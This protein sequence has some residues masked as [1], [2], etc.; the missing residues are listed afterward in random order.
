MQNL[1][2]NESLADY[3]DDNEILADFIADHLYDVDANELAR[4]LL[5]EFGNL[6]DV[7][8]APQSRLL[9]INGVNRDVI[10]KLATVQ[11]ITRRAMKAHEPAS[12]PS[13]ETKAQLIQRFPSVLK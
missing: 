5:A 12:K 8:K 2:I 7:L 9:A 10:A 4:D 3:I 13:V 1:S 11:K 6:A